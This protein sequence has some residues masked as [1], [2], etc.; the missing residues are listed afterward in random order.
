MFEVFA[1]GDL[2]QDRD[3]FIW[4]HNKKVGE[5]NWFWGFKAGKR[6]YSFDLGMQLYEDAYW[7]YFKNNMPLLKKVISHSEVFVLK[8][9]DIESGLDYRQQQERESH[10]EDIAVRRCLRRF[11]VWFKGD[12]LL[13]IGSS[14]LNSQIVKFHL[15]HLM[16]KMED[17]SVYSWLT[18][19]RVVIIADTTEDQ[20]KLSKVLIR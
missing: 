13:K 4:K 8:S 15:P 12:K 19:H 7:T 3:K 1:V 14:K 6:L 17:S 18:N 11:G 10:Y 9:R 2:G 5:G 20:Y 16:Y